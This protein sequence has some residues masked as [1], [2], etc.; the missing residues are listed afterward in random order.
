M[1]IIT[2]GWVAGLTGLF[3]NCT[4]TFI[5]GRLSFR[6]KNVEKQRTAASDKRMQTLGQLI[7]GVYRTFLRHSV[8]Q[9]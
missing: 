5:T 3:V 4:F 1:I 7:E 2:I 8:A 9:G 6:L